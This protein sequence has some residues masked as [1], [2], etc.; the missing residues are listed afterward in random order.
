MVGPAELLGEIVD[1]DKELDEFLRFLE[2]KIPGGF[3]QFHLNDG[4]RFSSG[5]EHPIPGEVRE[6]LIEEAQKA[7]EEVCDAATEDYMKADSQL[8]RMAKKGLL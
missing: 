1:K 4:R 6:R 5:N 8:A 3:F 2:G 7:A